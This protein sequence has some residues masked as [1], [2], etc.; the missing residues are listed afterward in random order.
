MFVRSDAAAEGL[1]KVASPSVSEDSISSSTAGL[2]TISH[3]TESFNSVDP[4]AKSLSNENVTVEQGEKN[5][6]LHCYRKKYIVT[7]TGFKIV[8]NKFIVI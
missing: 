4:W 5:D 3:F 2:L 1:L 7:L 6:E 8:K